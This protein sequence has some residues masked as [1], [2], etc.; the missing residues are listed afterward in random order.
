MRISIMQPYIFPYLGY[1]HLIEA[2]DRFIFYDDVNF[3]RKGWIN[4]NKILLNGNDFTF[5]VPLSKASQ[6]KLINQIN[7]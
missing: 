4:K 6:N 1:F 7:L 3:I 5:T 2:S